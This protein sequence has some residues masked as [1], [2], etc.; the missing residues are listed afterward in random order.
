M[1]FLISPEKTYN[2]ELDAA[3]GK[4]YVEG[5]EYHGRRISDTIDNGSE[6]RMKLSCSKGDI[7]VESETVYLPNPEQEKGESL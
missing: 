5:K 3:E 6:Q 7:S 2:Y 4:I 1:A